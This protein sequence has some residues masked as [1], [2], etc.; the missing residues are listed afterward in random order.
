MDMTPEILAAFFAL[1]GVVL[2]V[3][4]VLL[5]THG[6]LGVAGLLGI[7]AAIATCFV[8]DRILGI[9]VLLASVIAAP[10]VVGLGV[11]LWERTPIGRRIVLQTP[12]DDVPRAPLVRIGQTGLAVTELRPMGECEFDGGLRLEATSEHGIIPI[13]RSVRVVALSDRRPVVRPA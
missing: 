1:T 10:F 8:I 7:A 5:P 6:I 3:G 12:V 9:G 4:E 13:G 2:L 11:R